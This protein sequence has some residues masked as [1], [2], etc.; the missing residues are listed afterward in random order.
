MDPAAYIAGLFLAVVGVVGGAIWYAR[1]DSARV[2]LDLDDA[3]TNRERR[4]KVR[5]KNNALRATWDGNPIV[6]PLEGGFGR[7]GPKRAVFRGDVR[8]GRLWTR[9]PD[10]TILYPDGRALAQV[11][12]DTLTRQAMD[13]IEDPTAT[14]ARY[15]F[16]LIIVVLFISAGGLYMLWKL[17]NGGAL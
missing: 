15:A 11:E 9:Q 6:F 12:D 8:T 3:L 17:T 1:W 5:P 10:G 7:T 4:V 2:F 16:Y 14:Y 13:A